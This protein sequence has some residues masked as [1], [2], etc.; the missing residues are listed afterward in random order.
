MI[1][2]KCDLDH[3]KACANFDIEYAEQGVIRTELYLILKKP[4]T[5]FLNRSSVM[6]MLMASVSF[7]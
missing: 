6:L 7:S 5:D 4:F 2:V 1:E 3:T